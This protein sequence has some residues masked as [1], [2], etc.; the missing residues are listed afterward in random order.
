MGHLERVRGWD[1]WRGLGEV[2]HLERVRGGVASG[3]G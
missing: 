1:I 3:E 2:W